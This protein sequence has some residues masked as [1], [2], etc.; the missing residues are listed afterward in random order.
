MHSHSMGVEDW[1]LGGTLPH[2]VQLAHYLS[3]EILRRVT[4]PT[5]PAWAVGLSAGFWGWAAVP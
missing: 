4:S 1:A 2:N 5:A 3:T